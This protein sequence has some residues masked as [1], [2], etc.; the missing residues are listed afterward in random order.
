MIVSHIN[1]VLYRYTFKT[2]LY[3]LNKFSFLV[4]EVKQ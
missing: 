3:I 2:I 4:V 1:P